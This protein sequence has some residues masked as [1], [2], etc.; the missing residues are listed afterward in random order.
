M[1]LSKLLSQ[2]EDLLRQARLA[3]L[4]FAYHTLR[5]F[6]ARIH[7]AA[8]RGPVTLKPAAPDED[9]YCATLTAHLC[10]QSLIEEH[11]TE[12]DLMLFGDV[13]GFATGHPNSELTFHLEN[14]ESDFI[15]DLRGELIRAGVQLDGCTAQVK[16]P[17]A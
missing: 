6:A 4:A 15:G 5:D 8:L 10:S 16:E 14:L 11:F 1:K 2:R 13:L 9:R 12:E 3:N 7:R 17:S